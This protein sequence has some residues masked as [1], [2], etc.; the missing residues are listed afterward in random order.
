MKVFRDFNILSSSETLHFKL[1]LLWKKYWTVFHETS[2]TRLTVSIVISPTIHE[3]NKW[4]CFE[5]KCQIHANTFDKW[6]HCQ[7]NCNM[8]LV[9]VI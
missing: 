3:Q 2:N 1:R 9:S 7:F 4:M 8:I 5:S 6:K